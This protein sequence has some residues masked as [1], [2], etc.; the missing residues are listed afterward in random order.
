MV[1]GLAARERLE[2]NTAVE[3]VAERSPKKVVGFEDDCARK[4]E[5]VA[6]IHSDKL[7][8]TGSEVGKVPQSKKGDFV[9]ILGDIGK[10]MVFEMKNRDAVVLPQIQREMKEAMET[11]DADYG[12]YVSKTRDAL[13]D[14]V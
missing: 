7:E 2:I 3:R 12:M 10:R 13:P 11:R 9:L 8:R 1:G 14:S 6:S 4:L 5:W